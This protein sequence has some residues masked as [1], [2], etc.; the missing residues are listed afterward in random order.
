MRGST[1]K[2]CGCLDDAGRPLGETCPR[3]SAKDHGSWYYATDLPAAP[4]QRRAYRRRGGFPTRR[5]AEAALAELQDQVNKR[6]HVEPTTLTVAEYLESWLAA[7]AA[8]VANTSRCYRSHLDL[9]LIPGLGHLP[10]ARLGPEDIEQLYAAMRTLSADQADRGT[11]LVQ[12]LLAARKNKGVHP[13]GAANLRRVHSTL[14]SALNTAVKRRLIPYSPLAYVELPT[15]RRPRAVVWTDERV[16]AW[17]ASGVRPPVAVWTAAQT[18]AFLDHAAGDDLYAL[19]HLVALRGLRRGEAVGLRW[20]EI[21]LDAA[22][23]TVNRQ[24]VQLGWD[25]VESP[26]KA[27]SVRTIPLDTRTTEVLRTHRARQ[28]SW[29]LAAGPAWTDTSRV[30]THPDGTD[31]HPETVTQ[32]FT[33][34]AK[35]AGLPPIR[36]HDLRHGAATLAL[37]AGA[38]LKTVSQMLGHSTIVITADT[39]TSVLPE[40][41]RAAA[42][43]TADLIANA[44]GSELSRSAPILHPYK[45]EK[46]PPEDSETASSQVSAVPLAGLEPATR[47]LEVRRSVQL[48]YRGLTASLGS[49]AARQP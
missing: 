47:G 1:F 42:E 14:R 35:E 16:A 36:L 39:Y 4:G 41:A 33:K 40:H 31:L 49:P 24:V 29:R 6:S 48:S 9:Y 19:F 11:P 30:F 43:N 34:L 38:D 37:A 17:Q 20:T 25:T 12:R 7:K 8:I 23:L 3:L 5:A 2:R 45:I 18:A 13:V 27:D 21:D 26:P 44:R 28:A 15:G 10:L 22:L 32:R 46:G